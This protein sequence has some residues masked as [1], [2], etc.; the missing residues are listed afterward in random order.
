MFL[1]VDPNSTAV[2]A[3]PSAPTTMPVDPYALVDSYAA[4]AL[5]TRLLAARKKQ[6]D[7]LAPQVFR[8][9]TTLPSVAPDGVELAS[10]NYSRETVEAVFDDRDAA[11]DWFLLTYPEKCQDRDV[12]NGS[13]AAVIAAI[14]AHCPPDLVAQLVGTVREVPEYEM[15]NLLK[16]STTAGKPCGPSGEEE[17][18][19]VAFAVK[20]AS[21]VSVTPSKGAVDHV[22]RL[23]RAGV[24]D[25]AAELLALTAE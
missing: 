22:L 15:S 7:E 20:K 9:G 11:A 6:L 24:I 3:I 21:G 10:V 19:G 1:P 18:P 25:P 14:R 5:M 12:V 17:I 16:R 23:M 8:K 13:E 2:E 4:Q